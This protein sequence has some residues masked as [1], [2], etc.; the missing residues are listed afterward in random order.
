M[1]ATRTE[2][3]S[4]AIFKALN[5]LRQA[6]NTLRQALNTPRQGYRIASVRRHIDPSIV[7]ICR[8]K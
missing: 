7:Y 2:L 1:L 4:P 8:I 3:T 5:T 6:L